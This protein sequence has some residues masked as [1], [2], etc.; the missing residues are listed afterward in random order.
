MSDESNNVAKNH[1]LELP[2]ALDVS[3]LRQIWQSCLS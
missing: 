2:V 1:Q 3:N